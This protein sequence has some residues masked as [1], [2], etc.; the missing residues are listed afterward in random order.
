MR[1]LRLLFVVPLLTVSGPLYAQEWPTR[2][3]TMVVAAAAGGPIDVFGRILAERMADALGQRVVVENI[4]GGGGTVGA[5]RIVAAAPDGY[6]FLLGTVATH[7]NPQLLGSKPVYNPVSAFAP[8]AL[9]ADIPLVLI[10]RKDFP[11]ATMSEFVAHAKANQG[12][13][14]YGSAGIGS[15]AHL[16][17]VMLNSAMGTSI[18][19]VPYRGTALAMQDLQAGRLDFQCEI[20]VTA[21]QNV[22][23]GTVKAI[24]TLASARTPVLP[25]LPTAS[26][27]S[28]DGIDAY[29]WTANFLPAGTSPQIVTRLNAA[30]IT[31]MDTPEVRKRLEGL[32]AV[33]VAPDRRSPDYLAGF[34]RS[35][36]DKWG[37][38]VR[39]SGMKLE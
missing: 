34:V 35:E 10:A 19:H 11:A 17:C 13:L 32:G 21:V 24:A 25:D 18:Q 30:T 6:T 14:N 31:A 20:A 2:P 28:L 27:S 36:I 22:R 33:I 7:A 3:L 16:G 12:K 15:A 4:G 1:L 26:E 5:A 37:A 8:V 38:A 39:S 23:A 9:I 29:T